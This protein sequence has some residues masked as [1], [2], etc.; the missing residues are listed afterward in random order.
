MDLTSPH[1]E[2]RGELEG[3][4]RKVLESGWYV[5]GSE[6]EAFEREYA[7]YC[8][9][10][11]CV[12]V[13]NGLEALRLSLLAMGVGPGDEVIV[14]AH[15]FIASWL[16][17]SHC[18]AT[19]VPVEPRIDT[20]NID[21]EQIE[22]VITK[23]TRVIMPVHLYGQPADLDPI[24]K[25]AR[26]YGLKVLE[27]AA[28]AHGASYKSKRIGAHGDL[29]A[30]SFYPVK[31]LGALGDGGTITTNDGELA[32]RIRMLGNYGS[33]N[34]Y[35][36]EIQG[37]NS[38]LDDLQ[39]AFLRIKLD[40]L[41]R[42]N[43]RRKE[44]ANIY[45]QELNKHPAIT[46]PEVISS[47]DPVWHLFVIRHPQRDTFQRLLEQQGIQTMIHYPVPPHL[48]DAYTSCQADD[49][50]L[51]L[52]EKIANEVISLPLHPTLSDEQV[53][54]VVEAILNSA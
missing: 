35:S 24:L 54:A 43:H 49:R 45:L 3:A 50:T 48:S 4:F 12:G 22:E 21:P 25:L 39:A 30:W 36:H 14:P 6:V 51:Q 26:K 34:K 13:A 8:S 41:D 2:L 29:V 46:L 19:P 10:K 20:Y 52:T 40:H 53:R 18:G 15:T 38:R 11:Y 7:D 17:V 1:E 47:A 23:K 42:W 5:L 44:I 32:A 27:D 37:F 28:Q 31:N 9:A 33:K 16:A